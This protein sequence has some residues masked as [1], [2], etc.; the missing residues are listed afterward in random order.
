[1]KISWFNIAMRHFPFGFDFKTHWHRPNMI[2]HD[3]RPKDT[4]MK[5]ILQKYMEHFKN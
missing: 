4:I 2:V 5:T 3:K 1:M